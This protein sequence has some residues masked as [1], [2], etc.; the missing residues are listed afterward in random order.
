MGCFYDL[1]IDQIWG[2]SMIVLK[3]LG[4][5]K[6]V[7]NHLQHSLKRPSSQKCPDNETHLNEKI[8]QIA[9]MAILVWHGSTIIYGWMIDKMVRKAY[10]NVPQSGV[11]TSLF[12][13]D[14]LWQS[15]RPF[16]QHS[17]KLLRRLSFCLGR[18]PSNL[19]STTNQS[20]NDCTKGLDK[21]D[22]Q[23]S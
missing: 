12:P 4:R 6:T 18:P 9:K 19:R 3:E 21:L 5:K 10:V 1:R 11:W 8:M 13:C 20:T 23:Q 17:T 22:V 2:V 14:R 7:A 15:K 16:P